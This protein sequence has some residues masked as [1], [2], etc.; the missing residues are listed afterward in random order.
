MHVPKLRDPVVSVIAAGPQEIV[1][2]GLVWE[3]VHLPSLHTDEVTT[4]IDEHRAGT[5]TVYVVPGVE[6]ASKGTPALE[7]SV[8]NDEYLAI[9]SAM[10]R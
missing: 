2:E 4:W 3:D 6:L 1:P 8:T 7:V 5:G 10:P 9:V